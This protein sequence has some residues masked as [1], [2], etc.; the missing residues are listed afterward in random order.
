MGAF[1][2]RRDSPFALLLVA[3]YRLCTAFAA[4]LK[5]ERRFSDVLATQIDRAAC[6]QRLDHLSAGVLEI[7]LRFSAVV[8]LSSLDLHDFRSR[9]SPRCVTNAQ[10]PY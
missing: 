10:R 2:K 1:V 7:V 9:R 8:V 3:M 4:Y 5:L 6:D